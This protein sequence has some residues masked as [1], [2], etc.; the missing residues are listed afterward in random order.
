MAAKKKGQELDREKIQPR[1]AAGL[2]ALCL[3][4]VYKDP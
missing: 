1:L 2:L 3:K 4:Q